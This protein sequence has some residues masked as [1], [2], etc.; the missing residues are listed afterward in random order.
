M[1]LRSS[2]IRPNSP[3]I[4]GTWGDIDDL[5]FF[6]TAIAGLNT[7][8][9]FPKSEADDSFDKIFSSPMHDRSRTLESCLALESS[10]ESRVECCTLFCFIETDNLPKISLSFSPYM[11]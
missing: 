7:I 10:E 5:R 6:T 8:T 9:R 1:P 11:L 4:S 3:S 2:E